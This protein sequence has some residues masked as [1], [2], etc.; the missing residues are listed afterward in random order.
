MIQILQVV[1]QHVTSTQEA[2]SFLTKCCVGFLRRARKPSGIE[3]KERGATT[4]TCPDCTYGVVFGQ[5]LLQRWRA[6]DVSTKFEVPSIVPKHSGKKKKEHPPP[7][8][9]THKKTKK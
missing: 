5:S 7:Q 9:Q 6:A 1:G 3:N 2:D 8:P 4:T